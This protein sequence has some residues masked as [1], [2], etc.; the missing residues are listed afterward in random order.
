MP[1]RIATVIQPAPPTEPPRTGQTVVGTSDGATPAPPEPLEPF[2]E[3]EQIEPLGQ[4]GMGVV[5]KA[6]HK[7]LH[8]FEAVKMVRGGQLAGPNDLARFRFEAEAAAALD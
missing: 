5:Y 2:G 8:R 7:G 3:Y 1:E 6:W 4:G